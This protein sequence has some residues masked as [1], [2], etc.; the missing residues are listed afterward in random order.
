MKKR[1][2]LLLIVAV[3][4]VI[5]TIVKANENDNSSSYNTKN[6]VLVGT[7]TRYL[8]TINVY[9]NVEKDSFGNIVKADLVSSDTYDLTKEEYDN[10]D[11][12][13]SK[14]LVTRSTTTV[15]TTYKR[16]TT[17]LSYSNNTYRYQNQVNWKNFPSVRSYDVIGIGHYSDVTISGSPYFELEYYTTM[18]IHFKTYYYNSSSFSMGESAT[19]MLPLPNLSSLS[20]Y[21]YYDV[22]KTNPYGT[23][24]SQVAAGDYAHG[25]DSSLTLSEALNHDVAATLGIVHDSSVANKFDTINE[26]EVYWSGSW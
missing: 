14:T 6:A 24:T 9:E 25:I 15:E 21:Y 4:L 5:P 17:T 7:T 22:Q 20:I 10:A 3:L 23:V 16:M 8:K 2:L 12:D 11:I 18:G 13:V 26:A 1:V 19:F